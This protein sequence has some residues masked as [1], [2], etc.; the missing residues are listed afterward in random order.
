[1]GGAHPTR[2]IF[3]RSP[4]GRLAVATGASP[5]AV[6]RLIRAPQV[7]L[8][9]FR[10]PPPSIALPGSKSREAL[11]STGWRPWLLPVALAGSRQRNEPGGGAP[12]IE[13]ESVLYG[14]H[15][16]CA[17]VLEPSPPGR[18]QGEGLG[19]NGNATRSRKTL[20]QP[21]PEG[22]GEE[23]RVPNGIRVTQRQRLEQLEEVGSAHPTRAIP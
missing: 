8:M 14:F 18:G 13:G 16:D 10:G 4:A 5:W 15:L 3:S 1:V 11:C 17:R 21:L 12:T 20:A 7:R 2:L 9:D 23:A 19:I 22:E 6:W